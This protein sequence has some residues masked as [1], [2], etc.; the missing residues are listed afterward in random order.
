MGTWR[1]AGSTAVAQA[2]AS[3]PWNGQRW[4][5][6]ECVLEVEET[7]PAMGAGGR[8]PLTALRTKGGGKAQGNG[9]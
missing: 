7:T 6:L 3:G 8:A 5:L 1:T 9:C 4:V 2:R